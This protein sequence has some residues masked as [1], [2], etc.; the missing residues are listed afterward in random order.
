MEVCFSYDRYVLPEKSQRT[1]D[2]RGFM[3]VPG[4][5]SRTGV[6]KYRARDIYTADGQSAFPSKRPDDMVRMYR[7]AD[8][9]GAADAIKSFEHA[10]ITLGHPDPIAYPAGVTAD[11]WSMLAKGHASDCA[12]DRK[13]GHVRVVLHASDS[14]VVDAI[15]KGVDELSPGYRYAIDRTPGVDPDTGEQY[16]AVQRMIRANHIAIVP[17]GRGGPECRVADEDTQPKEAKMKRTVQFK[18]VAYS[19]DETE[20]SLVETLVK[21]LATSQDALTTAQTKHGEAVAALVTE[22]TAK[23]KELEAKIVTPEQITAMVQDRATVLSDCERLCPDVK[24][25]GTT[26]E[27]KRDML[28]ALTAKN[29]GAK[30]VMDAVLVGTAL[31]KADEPAVD[32]ALRTV[33]AASSNDEAT[34]RRTL[35]ARNL[36]NPEVQTG[37]KITAAD[38]KDVEEVSFEAVQRQQSEQWKKSRQ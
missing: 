22:H 32:V 1:M 11:N 4:V 33:I 14:K 5:V 27:I 20:A 34:E 25:E 13:S 36:A 18:G 31:D 28:G 6:Y 7:P 38:G 9:V 37:K 29:A 35:Q 21:D 15:D 10:P 30:R 16:D 3:H 19:L 24:R 26:G 2:E 12:F 17:S 8:E 23:V